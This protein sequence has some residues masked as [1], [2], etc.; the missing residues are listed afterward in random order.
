MAEFDGLVC[1]MGTLARLSGAKSRSISAENSTGEKGKGAMAVTGT[2][3]ACARDLGQGWKVS[4]SVV[5]EPGKTFTLAD[6]EGPGAIQ[7]IWMAGSWHARFSILRI[8]WD[9][10][11]RPSVECPLGDFFCNAYG[12]AVKLSSLAVCVNPGRNGALNCYWPMPFRRR[13]RITVTNLHAEN[14]TLYYQV[15]YALAPVPDDAAC[16]HAQF[17]RTNPLPYKSVYTIVDGQYVEYCTPYSGMF[18]VLRPDGTYQSQHRHA[19]YRERG[20][21]CLS[22]C[23]L[24]QAK[25]A[26]ENSQKKEN[27]SDGSRQNAVGFDRPHAARRAAAHEPCARGPGPGQARRQ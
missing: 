9:G 25:G 23:A 10:Q 22:P 13:C 12:R 5:I 27:E 7:H 3:A 15:D 26:T 24:A 20:T 11:E 6:I 16:F 2:G 14:L 18:Q 17:R 1:D 8:H 4:P 21:G 19:M